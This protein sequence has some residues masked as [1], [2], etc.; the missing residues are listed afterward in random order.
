MATGCD[1]TDIHDSFQ[2]GLNTTSKVAA[3]VNDAIIAVFE[4]EVLQPPSTFKEWWGVTQ[5]FKRW[6]NL[7]HCLGTLDSKLCKLI[8]ASS[9]SD[10][11]CYNYKKFFSIIPL[12]LVNANYEFLWID[13]G[14]NSACLDAQIYNGYSL[15][16]AISLR[17]SRGQ[18]RSDWQTAIKIYEVLTSSWLMMLLHWSLRCWKLWLLKPYAK[19]AGSAL[20]LTYRQK[21]LNYCLLRGWRIIANTFGILA[22]W[23]RVLKKGIQLYPHKAWEL[24]LTC[25]ILQNLMKKHFQD[26]QNINLNGSEDDQHSYQQGLWWQDPDDFFNL[27]VGNRGRA[28]NIGERATRL[29]G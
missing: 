26:L 13:V 19:L 2:V 17:P 25:I 27:N 7:P 1:L 29:H 8:N 6:W 28:S 12:P 18:D 11:S 24:I 20:R 15:C 5:C 9:H 16:K 14:A 23:W 10:S 22:Q 21:V 3:E 4:P